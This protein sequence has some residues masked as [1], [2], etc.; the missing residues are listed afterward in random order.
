MGCFRSGTVAKLI[1]AEAKKQ[2]NHTKLSDR[3]HMLA[4]DLTIS[5]QTVN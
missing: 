3:T 5:H 1:T 2:D 4:L